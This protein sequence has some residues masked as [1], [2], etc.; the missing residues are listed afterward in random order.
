MSNVDS[1]ASF[2]NIVIQVIGETSNKSAELKKFCQTF[3]LAQQPT[4]Y[5][6][7]NDIF[8]YINEEGEEEQV[9]A[10]APQEESAAVGPLVEDV[11]MPKAQTSTEE[12]TAALNTEVVDKKLE[13]TLE[14]E[15]AVAED[16]AANG[17]DEIAV[18]AEEAPVAATKIE[19]AVPTPETAVKT[20]DEEMKEPEKPQD[21]TPTPSATDLPAIAK[22]ATPVQPAAPAKP[23]TWAS[24]AAAA[25]GPPKP[26]VPVVAPK[27]STPPAQTRAPPAAKPAPTQPA[28][29]PAAEKAKENTQPDGWQTAGSDHAK[30]QNRPQSVSGPPEKEGTM[31]YV[32]N[33]TEK[34]TAE[35]LRAAL[36]SF[37]PLIYFDVNR[38]KV[39]LRQTMSN[40]SLHKRL[41][42][43]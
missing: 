24:R 21:P 4:G 17:A 23:L 16:S 27:T 28:P 22:P 13:E 40:S 10:G 33:V 43:L 35:D 32:R 37:G 34:V 5:F 9:D 11:E 7:L 29:V 15:P 12:P 30:R 6:V 38:S 36:S 19:E 3:V 39:R 2:D 1:Q 26:V 14:S 20:I 41:T 25:A 18:E 31:G 8:R 42:L